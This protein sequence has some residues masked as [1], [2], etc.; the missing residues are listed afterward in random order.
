MTAQ[1]CAVSRSGLWRIVIPFDDGE[2][3]RNYMKIC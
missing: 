2:S 1:R 3:I